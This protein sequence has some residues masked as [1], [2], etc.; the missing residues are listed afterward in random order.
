[1]TFSMLTKFSTFSI[2]LGLVA[3]QASAQTISLQGTLTGRSHC[4]D[5]GRWPFEKEHGCTALKM[6]PERRCVITLEARGGEMRSARIY[7][8]GAPELASTQGVLELDGPAKANVMN[9]DTKTRSYSL[10]RKPHS[11]EV[12]FKL[13]KDFRPTVATRFNVYLNHRFQQNG[14]ERRR[15][16]IEYNCV[17]LKK[18]R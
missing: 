12:D 8:P 14:K 1:M 3:L 15:S 5:D 7:V 9:T 10:T 16:W 13:N 4:S 6:G 2:V 11:L 18:R 17:N